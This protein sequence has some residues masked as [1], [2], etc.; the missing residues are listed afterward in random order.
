MWA[1]RMPPRS[2]YKYAVDDVGHDYLITAAMVLSPTKRKN[3][4]RNAMMAA[5]FLT[6]GQPPLHRGLHKCSAVSSTRCYQIS[7]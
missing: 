4:D 6:K 5:T 1:A 2:L 3:P 7:P